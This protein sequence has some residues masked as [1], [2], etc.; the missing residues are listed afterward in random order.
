MK[1]ILKKTGYIFDQKLNIWVKPDYAGMAYNDGDEFEN[2][3]V[4]ILQSASDLSI[5]SPELTKH[6]TDWPSL[7][8]LSGTRANLLRPFKHILKGDILEIG[9]GCGAITRYLGECGANVLA[10][11]GSHRRASITRSRTRDLENIT[12]LAEK[13]DEFSV[14]HKFDVITLIGVL[15]YARVFFPAHNEDPVD[16]ML[17]YAKSLLKPDGV[18]IIAIENQLGLKYFA[19]AKEDHLGIPMSG[20]E[21]LYKNDTIVTFGRKELQSRISASGLKNQKWWYP[22]PDYK[23]PT[24]MISDDMTHNQKGIDLNALIASRS[25]SDIQAPQSPV[26]FSERAWAP[27]YRND[28]VGDLAHSFVVLASS[29][30]VEK[31]ENTGL[32][33][34][35]ATHRRKVYAKQV[36]F[37]KNGDNI[38]LVRQVK[39]Y[40]EIEVESNR[41]LSMHLKD[42]DYI[43]G[44]NW[45]RKLKLIMTTPGWSINDLK[46]WALTWFSMVLSEI[47]LEMNLSKIETNTLLDGEYLDLIPRNLIVKHDG[48]FAFFDK[49]WKVKYDIELGY[50]FFRAVYLALIDI[51][52]VANPAI[53]T[54]TRVTLIF[55]QIMQNINVEIFETDLERYCMLEI[56]FR[57]MVTDFS[58]IGIE[59]FIDAH[60]DIK[61][62]I[63]L[64][65]ELQNQIQELN[66]K[67]CEADNNIATLNQLISERDIAIQQRDSVI[68]ARNLDYEG[69]GIAILE[70]DAVISELSSTVLQ[71]QE[72]V[73]TLH[74]VISERD[75]AIHARNIA[76]EE[77]NISILKKSSTIDELSGT[78][79][80]SLEAIKTLHDVISERDAIV[81]ELN[82]TLSQSHQII[83]ERDCSINDL[84]YTLFESQEEIKLLNQLIT[85]REAT[86]QE[87]DSTIHNQNLA[88]QERD[89]TIHNQNLA[90]QERDST[91]HNQNLAIQERDSTIHN[92]NLTI[93]ELE[94]MIKERDTILNSTSWQL[95][96]SF[97]TSKRLISEFLNKSIRKFISDY[98][99]NTWRRLPLSFP[100]RQKLKNFL[101]MNFSFIF[102][103]T[104]AYRDWI[105]FTHM[106]TTNGLN[107]IP[108]SDLT[109]Q[110]IEDI[111]EEYTPIFLGN[112]LKEKASKLICFYLPQ[113]HPIPENNAWWGE[114]FTEWTNVKPAVPIFSN[115]YQPHVPGELGYY[116]LL[117]STTQLRQVEL[118]KL[119]GIHGFC[120]Y[121]YWFNGKTLLEDPLKKYLADASLD[122]PFCLCWAN[123]N[124]TRRW[125]GLENELLIFQKHSNEDDL[126]F[127][128]YVSSYMKDPRYIRIDNK[129]LLL[130]YRPSLLP[131]AKET[132]KRWR[133][134]CRENGIGEI[135]L[136]YTQSFESV[137]PRKYGFDAAIEFPPN[138]M[139]PPQI[140]GEIED[141]AEGFEGQIYDW[142][143]FPE[144]SNSYEDTKYKLFRGVNPAWDNT[145]R[146]GNKSSILHGSS[147]IGYQQ[148][149]YNAIMDTKKRFIDEGERLVFINAW[150]EW[151]EGAHLEPDQKYGYSYLEST[152]L[153]LVKAGCENNLH[154]KNHTQDRL[155]IILHVYYIDVLEE[156]IPYLKK[157]NIEFKLFVTTSF[158]KKD[159]V[160]S[161]LSKNFEDYDILIVTNRGR[162][163]LPFLKIMPN[164]IDEG[165]KVFLKLHTKK[166]LHRE[167]GNV[168]RNEIFES[169]L[170]PTKVGEFCRLLHT[171][172]N[173]G[174]IGPAGHIIPMETYFGSNRS[175]I[176]RLA[177][178][179]GI[180]E[181]QVLQ[182]PF[183]AGTMFYSK[184]DS[185]LPLLNLATSEEDF[186]I[187]SGQVDGTLAHA[188]ERA[189]AIS[190]NS[191]NLQLID[192]N[193]TNSSDLVINKNSYEFADPISIA[194]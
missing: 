91:I 30:N 69:L 117:D 189:I 81:K 139:S 183:I 85:E 42:Q 179:M 165:F 34:H 127:I 47:N 170:S 187:E 132:A 149:L 88:I 163:V 63:Y 15:E 74:K 1:K 43:Y 2:R 26:F 104:I 6:C 14:D 100:Q 32:G 188:I 101:F 144:R 20:I 168:W 161:M 102:K 108:K 142:T 73:K 60:I 155:A 118:A 125:D 172:D 28:I 105:S 153:A 13:F 31:L 138:N 137:D 190:S 152:R 95:T 160:D 19:G 130:V 83:S 64:E 18:L 3:L 178:R 181:S 67:V 62:Q 53:D 191:V 75:A 7:Y 140:T 10:L 55:S 38:G 192:T 171:S 12:V 37:E 128:K 33:Y 50:L 158:D 86:I 146:R 77:L 8:H 116:N 113:F 143:A 123:E 66:I 169:L 72:E 109:I 5:L 147:P 22:F 114:G 79:S 80:Q 176:I 59:S 120:F 157:I 57:N 89:S 166:S 124:W 52:K 49:E 35:F 51:G 68:N 27:I 84:Y 186:E 141:L 184:I 126:A 159:K 156:I 173:I 110:A 136:A 98:S 39:L 112:P 9:S 99:R 177:N 78:I 122:L 194:G 131:S 106:G 167:D 148:W 4:N 185:V 162:D 82:N 107:I 103:S 164:V 129:P 174:M 96:K 119:Y 93:Q 180:N 71:S 76:C 16:A 145:A 45:E 135:Y 58:P 44:E 87:R 46:E 11:E 61:Q 121:F 134:W 150:N 175:K 193:Y 25:V 70:K 90:I 36:I 92:Q 17:K 54:P 23:L 151:A 48:T 115:H 154:S 111:T 97:R 133:K 40:P 29:K 41:P 94:D 24:L 182:T 21:D 56:D 65:C